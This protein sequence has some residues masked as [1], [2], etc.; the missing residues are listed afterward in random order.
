MAGHGMPMPDDDHGIG[1]PAG[2]TK[3][4]THTFRQAGDLIFACHVTGHY[5]AGMKGT[6]TVT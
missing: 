3:I 6:I 5:P 1:L 2:A 4:P